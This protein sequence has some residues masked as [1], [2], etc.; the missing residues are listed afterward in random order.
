VAAYP[1]PG[2]V[3]NR[4][5]WALLLTALLSTPT[6][7]QYEGGG[8]ERAA[9]FDTA[10]HPNY[11]DPRE[12]LRAMMR[13]H[14]TRRAGPQHF[15]V[16]GYRY[17]DGGRNAYILWREGRRQI[18]WEG[19]SDPLDRVSSITRSRRN[20]DLD[21]DVVADGTFNSSTYMIFAHERRDIAAD[22]ARAG[23]RYVLRR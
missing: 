8:P 3:H 15:C 7:A 22:C 1:T 19:W 17:R 12:G 4:R 10:T 2:R 13:D 5:G 18:L 16:V 23:R 11:G 14:R 20:L 6:R 9:T 21:T